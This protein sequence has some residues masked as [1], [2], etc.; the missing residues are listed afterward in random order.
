MLSS[1]VENLLHVSTPLGHLQG[2]RFRYTR[3]VLVQLS[4]NVPLISH[5]VEREV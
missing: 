1:F 5:S 3:V 2:E 4:E